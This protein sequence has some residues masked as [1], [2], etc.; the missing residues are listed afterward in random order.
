MKVHNAN[1][2]V[3]SGQRLIGFVLNLQLEAAPLERFQGWHLF[4]WIDCEMV[5]RLEQRKI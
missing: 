5:A 2:P 1:K 3:V 4:S